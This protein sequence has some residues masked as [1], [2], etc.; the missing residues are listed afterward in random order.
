MLWLWRLIANYSLANWKTFSHID[1]YTEFLTLNIQ[2]NRHVPDVSI[3]NW[4]TE[5]DHGIQWHANNCSVSQ[6]NVS[7]CLPSFFVF[8]CMQMILNGLICMRMAVKTPILPT[9]R[10][11]S[12]NVFKAHIYLELFYYTFM[13]VLSQNPTSISTFCVKSKKYTH[14]CIW[15]LYWPQLSWSWCFPG[16]VF[17]LILYKA[18][19]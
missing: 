16:P 13:S 3:R 19:T 17:N 1:C 9:F 15:C 12:Q 2:L 6:G 4:S 8:I 5:V 11:V 10:N 18:T 14:K 7:S